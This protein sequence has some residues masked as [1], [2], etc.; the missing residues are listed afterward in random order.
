MRGEYWLL[1][2]GL[3][4]FAD[5][6]QAEA[7]RDRFMQDQYLAEVPLPG[8]FGFMLARTR[9]TAGHYTVWGKPEDLLSVTLDRG[10]YPGSNS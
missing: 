6:A 10:G 2:V 9:R 7:I 5:A 1:H 8:G 3:S 4:M